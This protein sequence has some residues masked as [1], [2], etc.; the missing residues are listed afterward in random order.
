MRAVIDRVKSWV[1]PFGLELVSRE[2]FERLS[3]AEF[4]LKLV[5]TLPHEHAAQLLNHLDR[6]KSQRRQD[7]FVLSEL[8][9]KRNGFFVEFGAA[10][11]VYLS[12]THMLEK[13]FGWTGILAEPANVYHSALSKNRT[14][15]V[16][17]DCVWKETG[18]TLKFKEPGLAHLS[19]IQA[20]SGADH[21]K[22]LRRH[23]K[24][25]DVGTISLLDLLKRYDA[26]AQID[27]LSIDT[28]G[29]EF[30]ILSSF[31]FDAYSFRVITCEHNHTPMRDKIFA[32][33]S[34][35]GYR[36]KYENLS[37][38]DGWYVKPHR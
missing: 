29:S 33:L 34:G 13:E 38:F 21:H 26:P 19:T 23:R 8:N 35:H 22:K 2:G 9:F 18:A 20:Y 25:Y 3:N 36:R 17:Y 12:N 1:R 10:D 16:T 7:L 5:R 4:D 28:E 31:D 6:S 24:T 14:A 11:G 32:L 37:G 30:D 27:Y 15:H